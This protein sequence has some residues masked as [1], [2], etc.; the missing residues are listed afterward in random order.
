MIFVKHAYFVQNYN[1][2]KP[3]MFMIHCSGEKTLAH[4]NLI[5]ELEKFGRKLSQFSFYS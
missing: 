5:M 4:K 1:K 3:A 2:C